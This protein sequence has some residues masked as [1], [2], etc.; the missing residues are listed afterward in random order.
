MNKLS[1]LYNIIVAFDNDKGIGKNGSIPWKLPNDLKMFKEITSQ[2]GKN[3]V[4]MGRKTW[5]S[6]DPKYRPLPYRFNIVL[7]KS[8]KNDVNFPNL[9]YCQS[10]DELDVLLNKMELYLNECFIIGGSDIYKEAIN[11]YTIQRYYITQLF[12]K[13]HCDTYFP[14]VQLNN[15]QLVDSK[16]DIYKRPIAHE[17]DT[18]EGIPYRFQTYELIVPDNNGENLEEK[19]YLNLLEKII[20]NGQYRDDRTGVGTLAI[21]EGN[22][23]HFDMTKGFPLLTT[24]RVFFRGV[25]EELFL[26]LSGKTN[27]KI[28]Q[29]KNVHIWDD[30][31][32]REYLDKIGQSH[33]KV[34]DLGKFYGFQ[35]R[36]WGADYS[37]CDQ[38]YSDKGVDQIQMV[39]DLIKKS[40]TSRRILLS[41]WNPADLKEVCLPPCHIIYQFYVDTENKMLSCSMIMRSVD[42]LIG[43]PFNIASTAL[44][45]CLIAKTCDLKPHKII[46]TFGDT[47]VYLNHIAQVLEQITRS[48]RAFPQLNIVNKKDKLEDYRMEDLILTKYN[49]LGKITAKMAA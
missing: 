20:K 33:R 40:P 44:L 24:K 11:R 30:N 38:D 18:Y 49:P 5:E 34:G 2:P 28:L 13:F 47:H 3:C 8:E 37:D 14:P 1:M 9:N 15:Y 7:S 23:L 25:A 48:P 4:I 46:I 27:A 10:F 31:S 35:W 17:A 22:Q 21:F 39:I 12:D 36:H 19:A 43:C 29:D 16:V 32:S 6:I 41:A 26:F 42:F 45:T